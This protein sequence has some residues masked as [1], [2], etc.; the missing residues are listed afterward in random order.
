VGYVP[1]DSLQAERLSDLLYDRISSMILSGEYR[2][3]NRLPPES[4]LSE[5]FRVSRPMVR[6]VLSRLRAEGVIVSRKG[7]GSYVQTSTRQPKESTPMAF[8]H[9]DS[10]AQVKKGYEF[11]IGV[12]GEAAFWAA[13][14]RTEANLA[15]L[16]AALAELDDAIAHRKIGVEPDYGFHLAIARASGNDFFEAVLVSMRIPVIFAINLSRSLSLTRPQERLQLVQ[17]EH[18]AIFHQIEAKNQDE[19]RM[20]MR[21]HISNTCERVFE[22]TVHQFGGPLASSLRAAGEDPA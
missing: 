19:A 11:R 8:A 9:M 16:R 5:R 12:E 18:V 20:A 7:S 1:E 3:G 14:N 4:Q 10:L 6:E 15:E 2:E 22:G 21:R 17:A 13:Q